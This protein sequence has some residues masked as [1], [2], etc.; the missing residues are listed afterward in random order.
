M[1]HEYVCTHEFTCLCVCVCVCV[2]VCCDR[3]L[4]G[5]VKLCVYVERVRSQMKDGL[6]NSYG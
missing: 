4:T 1:E 6:G 5:T 3:S 2:C